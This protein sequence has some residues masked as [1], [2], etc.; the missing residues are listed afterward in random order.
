MVPHPIYRWKSFWSGIL[1]A[2]LLTGA[3]IVSYMT[4]TVA[5]WF[6]VGRVGIVAY[7]TRGS[8]GVSRLDAMPRGI[9]PGFDVWNEVLPFC[10]ERWSTPALR[11]ERN[12]HGMGVSGAHWFL[13]LLFLITWSPLLVRRYLRQKEPLKLP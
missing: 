8:L 13:L 5:A 10:P 11:W 12:V 3:W 9:R 1:V 4:P 2:G 6:P 7:N